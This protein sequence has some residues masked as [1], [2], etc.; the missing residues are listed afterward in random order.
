[1]EYLEPEITLT[2]Q[3]FVP[4]ALFS[5][6]FMSPLVY[7]YIIFIKKIPLYVQITFWAGLLIYINSTWK[8]ALICMVIIIG[9][10]K[11]IIEIRQRAG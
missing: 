8:I 11:T 9:I 3:E 1:M 2:A 10:L 5:I 4:I 6:L 7:L